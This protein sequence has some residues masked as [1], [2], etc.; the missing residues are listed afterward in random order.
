MRALKHYANL[1]GLLGEGKNIK[2]RPAHKGMGED[3]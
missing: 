1:A 3:K 2:K